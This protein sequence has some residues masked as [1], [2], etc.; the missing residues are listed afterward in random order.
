MARMT[1]IKLLAILAPAL[2]VA[3]QPN[4]VLFMADDM[5]MGDTSAYQDFTANVDAVQVHTPSMERLAQMGARFTDAHTPASRCT[6]TRY[7]L[8]TGR[9]AFRNRIKHYVLFGSQG[10]PMIEADRP[11]IATMLRD[12]GYRTAMFGKWH[13]GLRYR[14]S[15]GSPAAGWHDAD[16]RQPLYD[17]P[18]D[19]GFD[20]VRFTARSHMSSGPDVVAGSAAG[21][22]TPEQD[23]GPGHIHGREVVGATDD[24]KRL[25][26]S[27][28]D[29]YVLTKLGSRHSD[30]AMGFLRSHLSDGATKQRP[31]FLYLPANSNHSPYTPDQSIDGRPVAGAAR[32][33]AGTPMDARHDLIYENDVALGRLIDWL[34]ATDDPRRP[35][36]KLIENTLVIFTS[37]N[38][39]EIDS[40]IAT[41]PFRSNKGSCY[42]GGHRVPF[43]AA[44]PAGGIAPGSNSP[45]PIGLQDLFAT[46][47]EITGA[48]LPDLGAGEKGAEDS[49]SV[50]AALVGEALPDRPPLFFHDN[51]DAE[52]D[53]A[54]A[55][56][57]LDS[58]SVKGTTYA[59]QW[60]IFFDERLLRAGETHAVELFNLAEDQRE[61]TN[62]L[63]DPSLGPLVE[64][65]EGLALLH[66][67]A[68]G[69]RMAAIASPKRVIFDWRGELG[70]DFAG[71]SV[72]GVS[73]TRGGITMRVA[74]KNGA[75]AGAEDGTFSPGEGGLGIAGG[76]LEQVDGDEAL[77]IHFDR[78]VIVESAALVAGSGSC[79]GSYS[80]GAKSRLA[81][82]CVDGDNDS[83]DQQGI[84]GDIGVLKK[85]EEL[86]LS[87]GP[88]FG[89]EAPGQWRLGAIAV[90][91]L[92]TS[93]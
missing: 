77:V 41:G 60:K 81:I 37:D 42:E 91:E 87:A 24:G 45:V 80:V 10:D 67:N 26:T 35:G 93:Q 27:G 51:K 72:A 48:E 71:K 44:W 61:E 39:A 36:E 28:P 54:M 58:P 59:G 31:F 19:H 11:T 9:Y 3:E 73:V 62:R 75:G 16:L 23:I 83:K 34:E 55:A 92:G 57:R 38:G 8:L 21:R 90:R 43:I 49:T 52:G 64:H 4:I 25:I 66:R 78:D 79:G 6:T 63:L 17:T 40:N 86:E 22:N 33:K 70:G 1:L 7:G 56:M 32:T 68:G 18:L 5:G 30:H 82:Y 88:H 29:A 15:D 46:F 20:E 69:H 76:Q 84:L 53:D 2:A 12:G 47:A 89:V 74:G 85:G 50:L 65:L 14:R 13:V